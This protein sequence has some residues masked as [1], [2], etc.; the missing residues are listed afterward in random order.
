MF[1]LYYYIYFFHYLNISLKLLFLV[2]PVNSTNI[3]YILL[4]YSIICCPHCC[5]IMLFIMVIDHICLR[6][7]HKK[8]WT[9]FNYFPEIIRFAEFDFELEIAATWIYSITKLIFLH[10]C[11][12]RRTAKQLKKER[13]L[14]WGHPTLHVLDVPLLWRAWFI[15]PSLSGLI[16]FIRWSRDQDS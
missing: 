9:S 14:C 16:T 2:Y 8:R 6:S 15:F 13:G 12:A 10:Q 3:Y 7:D 5:S 11:E 1:Y 4:F